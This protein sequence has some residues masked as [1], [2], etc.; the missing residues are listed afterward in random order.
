MIQIKSVTD[1]N[2]IKQAAKIWKETRTALIAKTHA[3]ITT[4]ELDLIAKSVIE[5]NEC[6]CTFHDYHGFPGYI[7]IS[8]N[9]QLIHG[10]GD[11]YRLKPGDLITFD[12][13]VTYQNHICDAAF[14][15]IVDGTNNL[16]EQTKILAATNSAL[17]RAIEQA[18]VNNTIGDISFAIESTAHQFGY[19]V[20]KDFSGHGCGNKLHED[21]MIPCYGKPKTGPKIVEN[22]T[23]CIEPMLMTKSD[24]YYID[25]NNH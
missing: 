22:M 11:K 8:V 7:C 25:K 9:D 18:V 15:L 23:L 12:I 24:K 4:N 6:T 17:T 3:G 19:E 5:G 2:L 10:I 16:T 21:P 13:G 14:T 1:L 20:V